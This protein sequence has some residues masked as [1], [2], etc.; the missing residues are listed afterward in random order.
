M[1]EALLKESSPLST[2]TTKT[3]TR[4][5]INT[6][7]LFRLCGIYSFVSADIPEVVRTIRVWSPN[8][9]SLKRLLRPNAL[10][11]KNSLRC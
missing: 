3:T 6:Q 2:Y 8:I 5:F 10:H 9:V 1:K 7:D 4:T 11:S